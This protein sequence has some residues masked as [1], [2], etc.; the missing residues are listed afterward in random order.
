MKAKAVF[1]TNGKESICEVPVGTSV[2]DA[3]KAAGITIG[4]P[5]GGKG[6][7]GNCRVIVSGGISA[8]SDLE[9]ELLSN[10]SKG[11]RLACMTYINGDCRIEIPGSGKIATGTD[12]FEYKGVISPVTGSKKC[13]AAAVDIGTT[14]VMIRVFS[15]PGGAAV[16][17]KAFRNPQCA[18]GADVITRIEKCRNGGLDGLK[19]CLDAALDNSFEGLGIVPE[20]VVV[21]GN[22]AMLHIAA[23]LDPYGIANSPFRAESLF[24]EWIG[25]R[26]YMRCAAPYIGGDAV[27][28]LLDSDVTGSAETAVLTDVGT[29]NETVL[30]NGSKAF[31]CSSSAGPAFEGANISCGMTATDGAITKVAYKQGGWKITTVGGFEPVGFCGSGL[32]SAIDALYANGFI[33]Y[34][35]IVLKELPAFGKAR[36]SPEDISETQL[37]KSAVRSG[38]E[39]LADHAGISVDKIQ[40]YVPAGNFGATVDLDAAERI[41]MIPKGFAG[42]A[43]GSATA[44]NGASRLV[45]DESG[46]KRSFDLAESI[47]TVELADSE[48]FA[49]DFI[50]YLNF[51]I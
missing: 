41:G 14:T 27:A 12:G 3:A 33:S 32:I 40:K 31:A 24:G 45:L 36:L 21:T 19:G 26:Y 16:G 13:F 42:K 35:G 15:L 51:P 22:T 28:S 6:I 23:G 8:P 11:E 34:E 4:M 43:R 20:F 17:R 7:C 29:N 2:A 5:C 10:A 39:A 9:R 25:N 37:A 1:V 50:K 46:I 38:I 49:Q 48:K 44:L 30:W 18:Y 47:E